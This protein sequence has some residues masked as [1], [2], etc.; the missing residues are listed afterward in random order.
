[1]YDD[2]DGENEKNANGEHDHKSNSS[3][4]PDC[5]EPA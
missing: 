2:I 4:K 5:G 1:M 3:S